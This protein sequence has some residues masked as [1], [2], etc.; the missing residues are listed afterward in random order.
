MVE[1]IKSNVIPFPQKPQPEIPL[2]QKVQ[3]ISSS[4]GHLVNVVLPESFNQVNTHLS[5]LLSRISMVEA[6]IKTISG[7][8]VSNGVL[9]ESDLKQGWDIYVTAKHNADIKKSILELDGKIRQAQKLSNE[10]QAHM[11]HETPRREH[12]EVPLDSA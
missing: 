8:L 9:S 11:S 7:T 1:E 12:T 4:L 10:L 6:W 2:D 5:S 3:N